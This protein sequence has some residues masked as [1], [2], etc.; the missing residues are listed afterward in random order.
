MA[1]HA[2]PADDPGRRPVGKPGKKPFAEVDVQQLE[3]ARRKPEVQKFSDDAAEYA[4]R[5]AREGHVD[6]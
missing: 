2:P 4:R 1:K 5:L 3:K 6:C